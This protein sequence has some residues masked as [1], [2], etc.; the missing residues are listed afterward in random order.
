MR[1]GTRLAGP[2]EATVYEIGLKGQYDR[3]SFNLTIFDQEIEGF[4][5]NIFTGTGF[6]LLNAFQQSV[7]GVEFDGNWYPTDG[8]QLTFA[9]TWLDPE[10]DSFPISA[11]GDLSGTT[12][13]GIHELSIV[14]SGTYTWFLANGNTAFV[15]G[16]YVYEDRR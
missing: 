1:P 15:R 14:T 16:E 7:F 12:P 13:P 6:E 2:E 5:S 9:A 8:L 10:Y 11:V 3:A 4:Q